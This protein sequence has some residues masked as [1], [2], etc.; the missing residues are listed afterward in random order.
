MICQNSVYVEGNG[1]VWALALSS[2]ILHKRKLLCSDSPSVTKGFMEDCS[3]R[4]G[5]NSFIGF[6]LHFLLP[7]FHEDTH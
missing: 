7:L 5:D 1:K 6:Q 2:H 3:A 4:N